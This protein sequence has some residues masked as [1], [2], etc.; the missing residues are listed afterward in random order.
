[1]S[2]ADVSR[3]RLEIFPLVQE[4]ITEWHIIHFVVSTP[5]ESPAFEDFS[6]QLSSLQIGMDFLF[7]YWDCV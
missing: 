5:T 2:H 3:I 7:L 1:M 6:S 4:I